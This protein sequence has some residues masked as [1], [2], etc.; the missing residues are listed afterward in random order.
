[1]NE[2]VTYRAIRTEDAE[3]FAAL[4]REALSAERASFGGSIHSDLATHPQGVRVALARVDGILIGAFRDGK[5][6]GGVGLAADRGHSTGHLWGAF[7]Q[8]S[9]RKQGV[10]TKLLEAALE[11]AQAEGLSKLVLRVRPGARAARRIY[12]RAGFTPTGRRHGDAE[13]LLRHCPCDDG[14]DG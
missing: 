9:E 2:A 3:A 1:M 12:L 4:R 14:A 13:E 10:G 7:V 5:L 6:I 11:W 8:P